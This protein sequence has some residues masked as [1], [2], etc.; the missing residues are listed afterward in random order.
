MDY[1]KVI[2]SNTQA[3]TT[4]V[5]IALLS[6]IGYEGFEETKTELYAY[7][8]NEAFNKAELDETISLPGIRYETE[9]IPS[10]N[11]NALWESNFQPVIVADFCTIRAHFHDIAVST[12][13][14]IVITP[15]MSFGTG[16]H[17]TTQQMIIQM[18]DIPFEGRSVLDFGTGTGVLAILAEMLGAAHITAIDNDE[19][20]VENTEENIV[21]NN[22]DYITVSKGSLEIIEERGFDIIL[23]N[24]NRHILVEYM[25]LLFKKTNAGGKL[26]V[27]G[28]LTTDKEIM[29]KAAGGQGFSVLRYTEQ[30]NWIS[31]LFGKG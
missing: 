13:Y 7:I 17:A 2:F 26:L 3:E 19:W 9:A 20:S 22:C 1:V 8:G 31:I 15:K 30:D 28:L 27:S 4:E 6:D 24:I 12:P 11:W 10:Q 18:K 16:H 14:D 5:L 23:A 21:R 29:L 25:T